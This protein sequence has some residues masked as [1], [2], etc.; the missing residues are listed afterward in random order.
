MA[1]PKDQGGD[2]PNR[3]RQLMTVPTR[4][5]GRRRPMRQRD[6]SLMAPTKGGKTRAMKA[7]SPII[8]AMPVPLWASPTMFNTWLGMVTTS[9]LLH[10]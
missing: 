2:T 7:P 10:R 8:Q 6:R 5:K 3:A 4:M 9:R 1:R